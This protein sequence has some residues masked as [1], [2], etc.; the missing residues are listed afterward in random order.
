MV[1]PTDRPM[2]VNDR[3]REGEWNCRPYL[4]A[5]DEARIR[6]TVAAADLDRAETERD[7]RVAEALAVGEPQADIAEA[8]RWSRQRLGERDPTGPAPTTITATVPRSTR[9]PITNR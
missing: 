2:S 4:S 5:V 9:L 8:L 6:V 1:L 7:R 3:L